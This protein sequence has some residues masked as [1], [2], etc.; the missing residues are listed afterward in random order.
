MK[1]ITI[2]IDEPESL[3]L[4]LELLKSDLRIS[5]DTLDEVIVEQYIPDAVSWAEGF[6]KRSIIARTHR[7]IISD[8][9][10]GW[11]ETITLP[12][13]KTQSVSS[14]AYSQNGTVTTLTG[15]SSGSPAGTDYQEDLRGH[16]GRIMPNR[17]ESWPDVDCDV[18]APVVITFEAGWTAASN[19]PADIKRALTAS[20]FD[21]M[22]LNGL[23]T[24]RNGFDLEFREKLLSGYRVP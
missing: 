19:V 21:A 16:A 10:H 14:I 9:P 22:E 15:P 12:R 13:G 5:D 24:I 1:S 23:L 17:T 3:P 11:N 18:P 20:V 8:F 4:D 6:M 7:W 2:D